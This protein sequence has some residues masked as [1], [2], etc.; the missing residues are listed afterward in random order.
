MRTCRKC[1]ADISNR[2]NRSSLCELC[3]EDYRKKY[4]TKYQTKYHAKYPKYQKQYNIQFPPAARGK[5]RFYF[6]HLAKLTLDELCALYCIKKYQ[7]KGLSY[8]KRV[9]IK[10]QIKLIQA[11]YNRKKP[12]AYPTIE[13]V[14]EYDKCTE[15]TE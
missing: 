6:N 10:T 13:E 14:N 3:Q 4:Q 7:L 15:E 11:M 1:G 2:G 12:K 5:Y 9:D 8:G